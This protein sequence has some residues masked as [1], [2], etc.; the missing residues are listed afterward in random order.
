MLNEDS[1]APGANAGDQGDNKNDKR[2]YVIVPYA[3]VDFE[4]IQTSLETG[5]D[6]L[7]HTTSGV[8]KVVFKFNDR[9]PRIFKEYQAYSY[10]ELLVE[11]RGREWQSS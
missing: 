8:D 7:R 1:K 3:S 10:N 5:R 9:L 4:M 2:I 11:L 6:E